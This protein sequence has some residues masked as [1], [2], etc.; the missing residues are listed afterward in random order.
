MDHRFVTVRS[1]GPSSRQRTA[2][3]IPDWL[4]FSADVMLHVLGIV[5]RTCCAAL[6]RP[7]SKHTRPA[8][9]VGAAR[10]QTSPGDVD[11]FDVK[12]RQRS[13]I[14]VRWQLAARDSRFGDR[15]PVTHPP[16][17]RF[18]SNHWPSIDVCSRR[19]Q[20]ASGPGQRV[21]GG[22]QYPMP[23]AHR[24]GNAERVRMIRVACSSL[25]QRGPSSDGLVEKLAGGN[26]RHRHVIKR[27]QFHQ[28]FAR[29]SN[30]FFQRTPLLTRASTS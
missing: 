10:T 1:Y 16:Q 30:H 14:V 8:P 12:T 4:T 18:T 22:A 13:V 20:A 28:R 17:F 3:L 29:I 5:N 24:C 15:E 6:S 7:G 19:P 9:G 11:H 23:C 26:D 2:E 21:D 25:R 27:F